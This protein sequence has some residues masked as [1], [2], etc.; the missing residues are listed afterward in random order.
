MLSLLL[1]ETFTVQVRRSGVNGLQHVSMKQCA[2]SKAPIRELYPMWERV[3]LAY[4]GGAVCLPFC[5][6]VLDGFDGYDESEL[7]RQCWNTW[8]NRMKHP[9]GRIVV[10]YVQGHTHAEDSGIEPLMQLE[11]VYGTPVCT[12]SDLA[13]TMQKVA[14]LRANVPVKLKFQCREITMLAGDIMADHA[15]MPSPMT[16]Q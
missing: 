8:D 6:N 9:R 5:K 15:L 1:S 2:A 10:V 14:S 7:L 3:P 4:V 16:L 13:L 11:S 12:I